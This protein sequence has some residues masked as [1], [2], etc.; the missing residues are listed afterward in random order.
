MTL[1]ELEPL[2]QARSGLVS[3]LA[4]ELPEQVGERTL[5]ELRE[6]M[7]EHRGTLPVTFRLRLPNRAVEV[8]TEERFRVRWSEE[9]VADVRRVVAEAE[10]RRLYG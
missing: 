5:R 8:G 6:L 7:I 3:G 9:F 4:V 1:D 10:V 2:E